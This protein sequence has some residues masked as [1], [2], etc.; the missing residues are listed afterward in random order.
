[1]YI[2][3]VD[4][5]AAAASAALIRDGRL[6][7]EA[8][9]NIGLTHS[10]TL[11]TLVDSCLKNAGVELSE[12]DILACSNGPGSFTG[13][14]IGVSAL[15]GLAFADNK[16]VYGISTLEAMAVSAAVEGYVICPVMDAR[17]RQVYTAQFEASGGKIKRLAPDEPLKLDEL[18]ERLKKYGGRVMFL[19]DGTDVAVNYFG[20]TDIEFSVFPEI[21]KYQHASAVAFAAYMRY[22]NGEQPVNAA[23]LLPGYL[24]LS[25]AERER[26]N[27][28]V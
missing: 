22:N 2:L 16:P 5:S 3:A 27:K 4:T 24:R 15:K 6:I 13:I 7:S 14:R 28:G 1:M 20:S 26:N 8:F 10:Q 9:V 23:E 18:Y 19:G 11:M 17:C 21:Y 12:T 25:Q